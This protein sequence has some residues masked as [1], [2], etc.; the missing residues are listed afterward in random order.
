MAKKRAEVG[1]GAV[2]SVA[3]GVVAALTVGLDAD[4]DLLAQVRPAGATG[5]ALVR[6]QRRG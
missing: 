3:V 1:V 2:V 5:G 4:H 6:L